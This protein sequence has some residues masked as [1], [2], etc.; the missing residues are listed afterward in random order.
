MEHISAL[1]CLFRSEANAMWTYA[2]QRRRRPTKIIFQPVGTVISQQVGHFIEN[3]N[4]L[5]SQN[6]V[7]MPN[8]LRVQQSVRDRRLKVRTPSQ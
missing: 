1:A 8:S 6:W 2:N 5:A 7:G 3:V 4:F